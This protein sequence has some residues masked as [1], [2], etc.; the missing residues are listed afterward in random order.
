[1]ARQQINFFRVGYRPRL[2]CDDCR[3]TPAT[4]L[5]GGQV[6]DLRD[7]KTRAAAHLGAFPDYRVIAVQETVTTYYSEHKPEVTS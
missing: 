2:E 6:T 4:A 7:A 3:W 5:G 1:M